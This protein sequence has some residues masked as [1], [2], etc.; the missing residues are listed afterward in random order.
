MQNEA[1]I[2]IVIPAHNS[3]EHLP[4]CLKALAA[5]GLAAAEVIV[6]DDASQDATVQVA[7]QWGARVLGTAADRGGPAAARNVGARAA[8]GEL[9]L[10]LDADVRPQPDCLRR[11][12][13]AFAAEPQLAA[14][15]GSYDDQP[16]EPNFS[17][18]VK[19]LFHHYVHQ[20][21]RENAATFWAGCGA[22]R[23]PVFMALGGF[24]EAYRR[25][26]IEDIEL[27]YRLRQAGHQIRLEKGL[28]VQHLKRWTLASLLIS[29]IRDRALPWSRLIL[30]RRWAPSDLNL[31]SRSRL[32]ALL[33]VAAAAGLISAPWLAWAG[34]AGLGLVGL[35]GALNG[36]LYRFFLRK[37]GPWFALRA[38]AWH[39]SYLLYASLTL[40][41]AV[42]SAAAGLRPRWR[43]PRFS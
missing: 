22:T 14:C 41:L 39:L 32:S 19:N 11:V 38:I 20:T 6:V 35:I 8:R 29:D 25:P 28:Q 24:D 17:S 10:F 4:V 26:S 12:R 7:R 40:G 18:Q 23:R 5:T 34:P 37:R 3:A 27:G 30:A 2:S 31:G 13:A 9:L 21:A 36:D 1:L 33:A 16:A 42:G 43:A 15:F